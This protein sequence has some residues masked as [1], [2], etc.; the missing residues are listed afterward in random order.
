MTVSNQQRR[1]V[2]QR[3]LRRCEYCRLHEDHAVKKHEVDHIIPRKHGGQE[4]DD[5]LAWAC[6]LCNRYKGSEVGAYDPETSQLV[7]LFNPRKQRW[8]DHF[9]VEAGEIIALTDVGRVTILILQL[10][11][12]GRVK[13]R[14][15]LM[16]HGVYP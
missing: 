13:A 14:N 5:N 10:N 16:Q 1:R 12:P 2:A 9:A 8:Q 11:R 15:V 3:A 7:P 6:F 4:S